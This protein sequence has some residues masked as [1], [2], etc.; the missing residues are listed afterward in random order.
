MRGY[1]KSQV[2]LRQ[3]L[4]DR[5]RQRVRGG[6][7]TGQSRPGKGRGLEVAAAMTLVEDL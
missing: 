2:R 7:A 5:A 4:R 3:N 1:Q 6:M